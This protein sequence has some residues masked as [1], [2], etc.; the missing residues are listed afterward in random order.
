MIPGLN[1][2]LVQFRS[3][4]AVFARGEAYTR[5]GAVSALHFRPDRLQAVVTGTETYEVVVAFDTGGVQAARC[6]CPY[7]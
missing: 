3:T 7:E 6:T 2:S 1:R 4:P 5:Q